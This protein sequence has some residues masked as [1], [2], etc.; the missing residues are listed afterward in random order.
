MTGL[1]GSGSKSMSWRFFRFLAAA[2]DAEDLARDN[3]EEEVK[4]VGTVVVRDS[5][6]A[7]L[8]AVVT[9]HHMLERLFL[10]LQKL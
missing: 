6:G 3:N 9:A 4:H 10:C 1:L 2:A 7:A 5:R 8:R